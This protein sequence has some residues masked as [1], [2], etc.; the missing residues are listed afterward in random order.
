MFNFFNKK[1]RVRAQAIDFKVLEKII[2][3]KEIAVV[4]CV[5]KW[6]EAC[7]M[8]KPLI[9]DLANYYKEEDLVVGMIDIDH[10]PEVR[11]S[12][13]VRSI[14][15]ILGFNEGKLVFRHSG[16][17]SRGQLQQLTQELLNKDNL[18]TAL[19]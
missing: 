10:E 4:V 5:T 17:M 14:P 15:T 9:H 12:F 1:P 19:N 2:S 16:V 6:C 8:Q 13:Q 18:N 11:N 3:T 7:R